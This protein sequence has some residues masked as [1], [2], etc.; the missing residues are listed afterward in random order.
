M[1]IAPKH[2]ATLWIRF[3]GHP[4]ILVDEVGDAISHVQA[5]LLVLDGA[6]V[7][8]R[9]YSVGDEGTYGTFVGVW[10]CMPDRCEPPRDDDPATPQR[11]SGP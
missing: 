3:A 6:V 5:R 11:P 9:I 1:I 8:E 4:R 7:V 10:R 2:R